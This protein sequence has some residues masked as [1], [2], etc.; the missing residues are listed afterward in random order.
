M[1]AL[2]VGALL[3][4]ALLVF[5]VLAGL[6]LATRRIDWYRLGTRLTAETK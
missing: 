6:M 2:L 4:G 1:G 5:T 3:M